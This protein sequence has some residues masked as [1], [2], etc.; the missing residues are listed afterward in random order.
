MTIDARGQNCPIP[1]MMA[2]KE[3]ENSVLS[4]TILVD[5]AIAVE[6]LKKL[7]NNKGYLIDSKTDNSNYHV[8]FT[9]SNDTIP[10]TNPKSLE[11]VCNSGSFDPNENWA[12][13]MGKDILGDGDPVLGDSLVKM[14]FYTLS[15][16]K[17]LPKSILFMNSGVKLPSL[18]TQV[19]E[20]L[21]VLAERGCEILVCGACLD[22]YKLTDQLQI[23][24]ISNMYEITEKINAAA[25]VVTL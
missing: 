18:N 15:Q 9:R 17:C 12:L 20:H 1:V 13:F 7:A 24:S 5:N 14:Y 8:T 22:F 6:N 16:G 3:I 10:S 21:S 2:N 4:F 11:I 19:I 25:K 23:G